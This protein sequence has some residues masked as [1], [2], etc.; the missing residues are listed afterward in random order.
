MNAYETDEEKVEA[1]KG[2]WK[3]NGISVVGGLALGLAAVFGWLFLR[4][5]ASAKVNRDLLVMMLAVTFG[6]LVL[7]LPPMPG[8]YFWTLPLAVYFYVLPRPA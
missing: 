1:I 7:L 6:V 2:W 3:E 4:F 5:V 8:W